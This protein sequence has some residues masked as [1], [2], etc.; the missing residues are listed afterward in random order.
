MKNPLNLS[1][2]YFL[3]CT[4][5]Y[6]FLYFSLFQ[7]EKEISTTTD[8]KLKEML[9]EMAPLAIKESRDN[10]VSLETEYTSEFFRSS[11]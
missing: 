5:C 9:K 10:K 3:E 1:I 2:L 7:N 6:L 8:S 11:I 4:S